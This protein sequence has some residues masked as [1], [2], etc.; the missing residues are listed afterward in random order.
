[1]SAWSGRS[2]A[3]DVAGSLRGRAS[4]YAAMMREPWH[5]LRI[6]LVWRTLEPFIPPRSKL[7]DVGCGDG[8][9]ALRAAGAGHSITIADIDPDM[10]AVATDALRGVASAGS[11]EPLMLHEPA[12][13]ALGEHAE[14]YDVV[15]AHNVLEYVAD[16]TS[17]ARALA[18]RSRPGGIVSLVVANPVAVPLTTAVRTQDPRALLSDLRGEGLRLGMPGKQVAAPPVDTTAV[19][20][21]I[22]AAGFTPVGFYG[23]RVFNEVMTDEH[24]KHGPGWLTDMVEAELLAAEREEYR[25]IARHHHL[26]LRREN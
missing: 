10:V 11:W 21:E 1:M 17:F 20:D 18:G 24:R 12:E 22:V 15:T 3:G 9:L 23:I 4:D 6:E 7:L 26:V 19:V 16:R 13:A 2:T 5:Q 25:A 8:S 14:F